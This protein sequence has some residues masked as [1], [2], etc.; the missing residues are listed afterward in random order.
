[1]VFRELDDITPEDAIRMA[2]E[3]MYEVKNTTKNGVSIHVHGGSGQPR[4]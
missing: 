3:A 2:D 4:H 1:M